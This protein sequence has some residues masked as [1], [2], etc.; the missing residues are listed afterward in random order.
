MIKNEPVTVS[1]LVQDRLKEAA[2][3]PNENYSKRNHMKFF[4]ASISTLLTDRNFIFLII[5]FGKVNFKIT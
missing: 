5:S 2:Q 4:V 1:S 3:R